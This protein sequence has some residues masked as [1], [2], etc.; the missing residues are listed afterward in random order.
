VVF[1]TVL[2]CVDI[3]VVIKIRRQ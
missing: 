2:K 1:Q 3:P